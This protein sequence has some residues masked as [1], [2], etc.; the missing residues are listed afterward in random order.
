VSVVYGFITHGTASF[1]LG[2]FAPDLAQLSPGTLA[3][4]DAIERSVLA[5]AREL[6]FLR[7]REP[8]KYQW[9]ARD[10]PTCQLT[11]HRSTPPAAA[12]SPQGITP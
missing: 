1:Y 4:G 8:Y 12:D 3:I 7:G 11:L 6:D 5:G 10:R 9:G 2:G